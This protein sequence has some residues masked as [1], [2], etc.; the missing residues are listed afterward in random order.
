MLMMLF[1]SCKT[2][3]SRFKLM[4]LMVSRN[5]HFVLLVFNFY[6]VTYDEEGWCVG[7]FF[8]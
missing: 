6:L 7:L 1:M 5:N 8:V 3:K 4:S 2:P